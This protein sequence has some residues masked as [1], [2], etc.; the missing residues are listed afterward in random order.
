MSDRYR[1]FTKRGKRVKPDTEIAD[2]RGKLWVFLRVSRV[3]G[4]GTTGR[5]EV[6][7]PDTGLRREFFPQVFNLTL[8]RD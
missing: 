8:K 7:E 5:V 1:A 3:P 6:R 2:F 4:P